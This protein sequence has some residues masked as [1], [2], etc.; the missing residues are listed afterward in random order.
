VPLAR[1]PTL[2]EVWEN[3]FRFRVTHAVCN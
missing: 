1:R 3:R 2:V